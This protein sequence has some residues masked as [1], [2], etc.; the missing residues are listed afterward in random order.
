MLMLPPALE[1]RSIIGARL[2][3][4]RC[5]DANGCWLWTGAVSSSGYGYMSVQYKDWR[6]HR[7]SY[8]LFVG[9]LGTKLAC[10]RCDVKLCFNPDHLFKGTQADNISDQLQKGRHHYASRA[11]CSRGHLLTPENTYIVKRHTRNSE[12]RCKI[13]AKIYRQKW[14]AAL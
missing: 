13:C 12:R 11:T 7:L 8:E 5:I 14:E 3:A 10:H 6:V 9:K 1:E 4:R 2:L